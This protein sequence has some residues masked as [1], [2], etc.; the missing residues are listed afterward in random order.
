[1]QVPG[2]NSHVFVCNVIISFCFKQY[3]VFA[4][5]S[6]QL[7]HLPLGIVGIEEQTRPFFKVSLIAAL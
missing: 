3:L 4:A 5:P 7:G 6:F 1:M 2:L